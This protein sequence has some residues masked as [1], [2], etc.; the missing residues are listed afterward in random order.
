MGES[1]KHGGPRPGS[2]RRS[3]FPNKVPLAASVSLTAAARD[4]LDAAAL[5]L[6]ASKL[7]WSRR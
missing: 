4:K 1:R 5:R 2:G 6:R 7:V 3:L